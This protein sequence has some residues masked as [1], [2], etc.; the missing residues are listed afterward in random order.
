MGDNG[1]C[2]PFDSGG[3]VRAAAGDREASAP[4]AAFGVTANPPDPVCDLKVM[5]AVA[6]LQLVLRKFYQY[7]HLPM[8]RLEDIFRAQVS[9][10]TQIHYEKAPW[11]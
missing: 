3:G 6:A 9:R 8:V 4:R 1:P 7:R 10:A 11:A 5:T 2:F